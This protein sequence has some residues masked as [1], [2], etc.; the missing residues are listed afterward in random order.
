MN[1]DSFLKSFVLFIRSLKYVKIV[2]NNK[3]YEELFLHWYN[4]SKRLTI[5]IKNDEFKLIDN[6]FK[7]TIMFI[8]R[9]LFVDGF[10][11]EGNEIY[12]KEIIK[13]FRKY[14]EK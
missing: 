7:K 12:L 5:N 11:Y 13:E 9:V 2:P 14:E 10:T 8:I 6:D 4:L 1:N 3:N